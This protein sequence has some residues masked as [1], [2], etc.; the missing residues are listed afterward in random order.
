MEDGKSGN[1]ARKVCRSDLRIATVGN[2]NCREKQWEVVLLPSAQLTLVHAIRIS[3]A[4]A[5]G[6][7]PVVSDQ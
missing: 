2:R 1:C 7:R 6:Q 3:I 5:N 4:R